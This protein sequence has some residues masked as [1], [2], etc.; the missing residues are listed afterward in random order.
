MQFRFMECE[1]PS[2]DSSLQMLHKRNMFKWV[3]LLMSEL[4]YKCVSYL[5]IFLNF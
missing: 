1:N 2:F 5:S 3:I 4:T